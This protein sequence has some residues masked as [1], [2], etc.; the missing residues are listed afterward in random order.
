MV[1]TRS[2]V[3]RR[4]ALALL[5]RTRAADDHQVEEIVTFRADK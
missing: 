4:V 1:A 3:R 2:K 5:R